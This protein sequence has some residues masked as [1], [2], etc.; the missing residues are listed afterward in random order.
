MKTHCDE[1]SELFFSKK[2]FES[3]AYLFLENKVLIVFELYMEELVK[4][5]FKQLR[6]ET[7]QKCFPEKIVEKNKLTT[8]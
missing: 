7:P 8:L 5:L 1:L 3:I 2:R 4:E 6:N